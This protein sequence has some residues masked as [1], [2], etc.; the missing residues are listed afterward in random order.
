M[1]TVLN[2]LSGPYI[3]TFYFEDTNL[4]IG[5]LCKNKTSESMSNTLDILQDKLSV[6]EF[7]KLFGLLLTDRG[8]EFEQVDLFIAN[9]NTGEVRLNIFYCDPYQSS[10]KPHI[11]NNHNYL[12]DIIT[13][14]MDLSILTQQDLDL[15]FSHINS[16]PRKSLNDKS[17][18]EMFEF[19]YGSDL[20]EK[21][22]IKQ[23][24]RDEVILKPYLILN[25]HK[26]K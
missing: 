3:Q 12:R 25:N 17:P 9:K 7:A 13:N 16:T 19:L 6:E 14:E 5:F 20:L 23:I 2:S 21:L 24:K 26:N 15:A 1:D 10:Q 22:N 11:E 4:M 18:Y 8:V